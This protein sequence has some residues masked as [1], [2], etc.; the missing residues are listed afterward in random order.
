MVLSISLCKGG[1]EKGKHGVNMPVCLSVISGR[2]ARDPVKVV[3]E[4]V[5][6]TRD[7]RSELCQQGDT[8][9]LLSPSLG[10][11]SSG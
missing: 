2:A 4:Q 5:S 9:Y 11:R 8:V 1:K 3:F 6:V 10:R 7:C